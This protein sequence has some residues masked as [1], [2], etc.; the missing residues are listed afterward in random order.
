MFPFSTLPSSRRTKFR[1]CNGVSLIEVLI[2]VGIVAV[3]AMILMPAVKSGVAAAN[4]SKCVGNLKQLHVASIAW[5]V[6]NN[7]RIPPMID[8]PATETSYSTIAFLAPYLGYE[9]LRSIKSTADVPVWT[10]PSNPKQ[11][12]YGLNYNYLSWDTPNPPVWKTFAEMGGR[13]G[14]SSKI[15]YICDSEFVSGNIVA[16]GFLDWR[17]YVRPPV[18]PSPWN[19]RT[20]SFRHPGKT[21]N[22][23]WLD[24]HVTAEVYDSKPG[25]FNDPT[26]S[27]WGN[28]DRNQW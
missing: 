3:L 17:A 16:K 26:D 1:S 21:C 27:M 13:P 28:Y 15:V 10:C 23:L 5:S 14:G 12:G 22:V 18:M 2:A 20:P 6:D 24:G 25:G 7:G 11:F 8:A 4:S 9:D 19:E